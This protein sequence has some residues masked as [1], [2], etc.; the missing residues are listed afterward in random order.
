MVSTSSIFAATLLMNIVRNHMV[1]IVEISDTRYLVDV[2]F[3]AFYSICQVR[4][5][6]YIPDF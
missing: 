2:G 5:H 1:N 3:G 6:P 4:A